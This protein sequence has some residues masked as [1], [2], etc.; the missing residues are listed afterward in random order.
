MTHKALVY[1]SVHD[2]QTQM[3]AESMRGM[4]SVLQK[5][6]MEDVLRTHERYTRILDVHRRDLNLRAL[7]YSTI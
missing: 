5:E 7:R 6:R 1:I 2:R 4:D 3:T